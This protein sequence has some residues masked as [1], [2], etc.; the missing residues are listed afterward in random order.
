MSHVDVSN[1]FGRRWIQVIQ[2]KISALNREISVSEI[3]Q[4]MGFHYRKNLYP[5]QS[6]IFSPSHT[7]FFF[8]TSG[9]QRIPDIDTHVMRAGE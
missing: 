1:I 8:I 3:T 5:I 4:A 9:S 7:F 6:I 2:Y